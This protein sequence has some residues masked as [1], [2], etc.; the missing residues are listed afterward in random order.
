MATFKGGYDC[1]FVAA[2]PS[3]L[4]CPVCLLTVREPHVI[5]CC[6]NQFCRPCIQRIQNENKSCPLCNEPNFTTFL[7]KG[8]MREVNSLMVRCPHKEIGCGWEGEL[9]QLQ[10]H[11]NPGVKSQGK[12]CG[13]VLVNCV[14]KCGKRFPRRLIHEHELEKCLKRPFE[15]QINSLTKKLDAVIA[16]N[17]AIKAEN[18]ILQGTVKQLQ[19]S[20]ALFGSFLTPTPPFYFTLSNVKHYMQED[21]WWRSPHFYSHVGG[22]KM[23]VDVCP[24]GFNAAKGTHLSLFVGIMRGEYDDKLQWPF[25]GKVTIQ[26]RSKG[27]D[28]WGGDVV[29]TFDNTTPPG[30]RDRPLDCLGNRSWGYVKFITHDKMQLYCSE[31]QLRFRICSVLAS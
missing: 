18:K 31:D 7:H 24:N 22:Y 6:G 4:E 25:Q 13:F 12:G 28:V 1:E 27:T 16:E 5:S 14:Y 11:L 8:V 21:L 26:M 10:Q 29:I 19:S 30:S 20:C 3:S 17:E 23:L 9:G 15:V 2:P